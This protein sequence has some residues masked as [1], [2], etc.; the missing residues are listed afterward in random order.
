MRFA[1]KNGSL[2][3]ASKLHSTH[4]LQ[5]VGSWAPVCGSLVCGERHWPFV[6]VWRTILPPDC[7]KLVSYAWRSRVISQQDSETYGGATWSRSEHA[8]ARHRSQSC[9]I[10]PACMTDLHPPPRC[11]RL[12]NLPSGAQVLPCC[13]NRQTLALFINVPESS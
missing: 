11:P 12:L 7:G 8:S 2:P 5:D 3:R 9:K 1:L 10:L 4:S 6:C 13:W